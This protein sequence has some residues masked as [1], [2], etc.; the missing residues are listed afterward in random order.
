MRLVKTIWVSR[1]VL[2]G[3]ALLWLVM[4][5]F[6][7]SQPG[8]DTAQTSLSLALFLLRVFNLPQTSLQPFHLA[9]RTL[10]HIF[11]FFVLGALF[12]A[13]LH[14]TYPSKKHLWVWAGVITGLI[15]ILDEVKK[16]FILGRHLSWLEAGLNVL[17][18]FCGIGAIMVFIHGWGQWKRYR[19]HYTSNIEP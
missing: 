16:L 5:T 13:A 12:Y 11:G 7:S 3:L 4:I 18:A 2:W 6:L 10:A 9:L 14:S 15:G 17:G 1:A 19:F 8:P